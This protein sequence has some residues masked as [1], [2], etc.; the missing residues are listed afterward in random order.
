M[1]RKPKPTDEANR[2]SAFPSD[3][4]LAN[5]TMRNDA[6]NFDAESALATYKAREAAFN[7]AD[8]D[9]LDSL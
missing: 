4:K 7:A 9:F 1:P 2:A 8:D 3:Q 5:W 6:D